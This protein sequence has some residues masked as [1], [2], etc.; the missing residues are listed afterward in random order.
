MLIVRRATEN[1][2]LRSGSSN[3][4]LSFYGS[5]AT[6][7]N[8]DGT[9]SFFWVRS[10]IR[11]TSL[12]GQPA[13]LFQTEHDTQP[14]RSQPANQALPIAGI[15]MTDCDKEIHSVFVLFYSKLGRCPF[16]AFEHSKLD[17]VPEGRRDKMLNYANL[18]ERKV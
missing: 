1:N 17:A 5:W 18:R 2:L 6:S 11:R 13:Y 4:T 3:S 10:L 15:C 16:Y 12:L 8:E 14:S 9:I 7:L